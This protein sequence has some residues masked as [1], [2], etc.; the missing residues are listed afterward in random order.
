MF[1]S[2]ESTNLWARRFLLREFTRRVR[3]QRHVS[4][5]MQCSLYRQ[6][7]APQ[8]REQPTRAQLSHAIPRPPES[9]ADPWQSRGQGPTQNATGTWVLFTCI[10]S[11]MFCTYIYVN[12]YLWSI[13]SYRIDTELFTVTL[14]LGWRRQGEVGS[15]CYVLHFCSNHELTGN[16]F[17]FRSKL[18][19]IPTESLRLLPRATLLDFKIQST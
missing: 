5:A 12:I 7:P 3:A 18:E 15:T 19:G 6:Q 16:I 14:L 8:K 1:P 9:R 17:L 2:F 4:Q 10:R 13:S 11:Y